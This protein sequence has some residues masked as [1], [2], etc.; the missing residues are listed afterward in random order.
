MVY[1]WNLKALLCLKMYSQ[2]TDFHLKTTALHLNGM[3]QILLISQDDNSNFCKNVWVVE[4]ERE[5]TE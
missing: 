1:W 5:T 3:S 2:C 4:K